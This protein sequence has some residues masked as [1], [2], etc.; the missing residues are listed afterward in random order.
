MVYTTPLSLLSSFMLI[1]MRTGQAI[2]LINALSQVSVSCWVLLLSCGVARSRSVVS[3][4]SIEAEYRAL[5]TSH[6]SLSGFAGSW[7]TRMLHSPLPLLLIVT[8]VVLS[9]LLIMMSSMNAPSTMRLTATSL[10][11][12]SRKAI[13][14]CSPSLLLTSLLISSPR[15]TRLVIFEILYLNSS[16]LPPYHLEFK[17][18]CYCIA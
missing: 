10:A 3:C 5:L 1:Q 16:W 6:A 14:S 12:I 8:I 11:N 13:S 7:L 9:T 18:G 2:R 4:S 17:R 15:V